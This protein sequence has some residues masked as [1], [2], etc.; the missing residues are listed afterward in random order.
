MNGQVHDP[1]AEV[2]PL[3]YPL[4]QEQQLAIRQ[5]FT[6]MPYAAHLGGELTIETVEHLVVVLGRLAE[7]LWG[8]AA[9]GEP[10]AGPG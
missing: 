2:D 5:A 10:T 7:R 9:R 8:V 1:E 6:R 4:T 3:T